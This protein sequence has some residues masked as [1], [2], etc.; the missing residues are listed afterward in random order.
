MNAAL[1]TAK[2]PAGASTPCQA[3]STHPAKDKEMNKAMDNTSP[4][5]PASAM[6]TCP[7]EW[8]LLKAIYT[9]RG[10]WN[11]YLARSLT[12]DNTPLTYEPAREALKQWTHPAQNA[13][14]AREALEMAIAENEIGDSELTPAMMKAALGWLEI[15]MDRRAAA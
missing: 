15:A 12:D 5:L 4:A 11:L 1:Q 8:D 10:E 9:Y 3:G 14:E 2:G 13:N 7:R 6:P